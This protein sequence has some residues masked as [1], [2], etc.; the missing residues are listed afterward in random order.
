LCDVEYI[1]DTLEPGA[2]GLERGESQADDGQSAKKL[3]LAAYDRMTEA[4]A[5]GTEYETR[6]F[7]PPGR[8]PRRQLS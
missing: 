5:A 2:D 8:G 4:D 1:I 7:P 6:I 3:V